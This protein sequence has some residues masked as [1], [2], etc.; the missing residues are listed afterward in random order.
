[1]RLNIQFYNSISSYLFSY[2]YRRS[3]GR[4]A[5]QHSGRGTKLQAGRLL[6][7]DQVRQL[8]CINLPNPSGRTRLRGLVSP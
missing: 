8:N 1:M 2:L 7:R 5:R 3:D 6:V 4:G